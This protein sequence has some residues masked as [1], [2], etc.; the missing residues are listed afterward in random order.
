M[1]HQ[2]WKIPGARLGWGDC[3]LV[4]SLGTH[5][6]N[7]HYGSSILE[8][9][10]GWAGV[11]RLLF[12][13]EFGDSLTEFSLWIINP[14]K[15]RGLGWG[16]GDLFGGVL[17]THSQNPHYGSSILVN[18]GGW[19]GVGRL[20][21]GGEFGD[22]LT[23]SSLWIINPGKSR[24]LGWGGGGGGTLFGVEFGDSLTESS[25]WVINPGKSRGLGWGGETVVWW[26]VWGL[27]HRILTMDHQSR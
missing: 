21:F 23:E 26:R 4:E 14:G 6:Q 17:G 8:N 7:P 18:P 25:L 5:S 27:T 13:G 16:G 10:G 1:D 11:G 12:G 24:G 15:S 22:S 9:P 20:L 19:A 2:S 3:C